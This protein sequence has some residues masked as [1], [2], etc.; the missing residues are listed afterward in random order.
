MFS[1]IAARNPTAATSAN[2]SSLK[3]TCIQRK[4][5]LPALAVGIAAALGAHV[6]I[7]RA[8]VSLTTGAFAAGSL[9]PLCV[10]VRTVLR[11]RF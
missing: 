8:N 5:G 6:V 7:D 4:A 11:R 9:P 2:D 3:T 1:L 10:I